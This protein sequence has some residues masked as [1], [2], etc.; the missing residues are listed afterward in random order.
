MRGLTHD[1]LGEAAWNKKEDMPCLNWQQN[2]KT[3]GAL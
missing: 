1:S 3:T 2:V